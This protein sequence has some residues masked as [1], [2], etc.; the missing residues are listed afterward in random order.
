MKRIAPD[1]FRSEDVVAVSRSLLG[2]VLCTEIGGEVT[3]AVIAETEAYAGVSDRASHAYGGRRTKRTEP[4]YSAGGVAYVYL[5]YGIHH[6]FNV[7]TGPRD[8][9]HAVLVR[10]GVALLGAK[11]MLLRRGKPAVDKTLLAGPGALAQA[12]AIST[13]MTGTDLTGDRIWIE[14]HGI[15]MGEESI[16]VTPRIGVDYAGEDA[17]R[18]Y[19][20]VVD[21][22]GREA[23][24]DQ[25][26]DT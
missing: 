11:T 7:V 13:D 1:F 16:R 26:R 18:P 2:K 17:L 4:M 24:T 6:L 23:L 5:C 21:M 12:L 25:L 8:T 19:R 9:P 14:D 22:A 3:K 15:E 10:A 20:F